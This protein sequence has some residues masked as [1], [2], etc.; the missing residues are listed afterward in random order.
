MDKHCGLTKDQVIERMDANGKF[1]YRFK[2]DIEGENGILTTVTLRWA[3]SCRSDHSRCWSVALLLQDSRFDG[4]DYESRVQDHRGHTCRGWHRHIW[5]PEARHCRIKECLSDFGNFDRFD[6]FV[7]DS[8]I[9]L[10]IV[11]EEGGEDYAR[12]GMLFG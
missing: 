3:M 1:D 10:K 12:S 5:N 4:I 2:A 9:E 8:C 6:D 11:L 7:R